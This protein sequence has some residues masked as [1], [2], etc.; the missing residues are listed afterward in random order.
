MHARMYAMVS[1]LKEQ[2]CSLWLTSVLPSLPLGLVDN[3]RGYRNPEFFAKM[4]EHL[5]IDQYGT[6]FAPEVGD[7]I[8][9]DSRPCSAALPSFP[10]PGVSRR[11]HPSCRCLTPSRCR[12]R[13]TWMRSSASGRPRT[14]GAR[15]RA[16][17]GRA[18]W[19]STSPVSSA[20][21]AL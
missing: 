7:D 11:L 13:I 15:R 1:T 2:H 3:R 10:E 4:V 17:R 5:E 8:I 12:Q 20:D 14:S 6:S 19:S 18:A 16:R 21:D 9:A